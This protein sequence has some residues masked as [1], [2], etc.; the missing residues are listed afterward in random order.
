MANV[1][2]GLRLQQ[3]RVYQDFSLCL[4]LEVVQ[5]RARTSPGTDRVKLMEDGKE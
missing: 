5:G 2:K 4:T 3:C 1:K